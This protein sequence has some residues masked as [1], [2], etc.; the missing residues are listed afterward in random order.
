MKRELVHIYVGKD[1]LIKFVIRQIELV[2][3]NCDA[4]AIEGCAMIGLLLQLLSN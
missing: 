1:V 3:F 2:F 4:R